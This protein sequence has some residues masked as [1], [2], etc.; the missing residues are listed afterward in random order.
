MRKKEHVIVDSIVSDSGSEDNDHGE[1][2]T[3]TNVIAST[4]P[5]AR[6]KIRRKRRFNNS[7]FLVDDIDGPWN[8]NGIRCHH[9]RHHHH[10]HHHHRCCYRI[11]MTFQ[12]WSRGHIIG[13]RNRLKQP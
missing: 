8:L 3:V 5:S 7:D 2:L 1:T 10:H 11:V 13:N 9:H 6:E 12:V 4:L